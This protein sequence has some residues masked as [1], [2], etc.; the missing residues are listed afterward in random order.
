MWSSKKKYKIA[1]TK[2]H[3]IF[4]PVIIQLPPN[5][6]DCF[7]A[8]RPTEPNRLQHSSFQPR[9]HGIP[10]LPQAGIAPIS[11][12][13]LLRNR[14]DLLLFKMSQSRYHCYWPIW[15]H[16]SEHFNVFGCTKLHNFKKYIK[17]KRERE[18]F[19]KWT[20]QHGT[21]ELFQVH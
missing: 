18:R 6:R 15:L 19:Q 16:D 5:Y 10:L 11:H 3:H 7:S 8:F 13:T 17:N 12:I 2:S 14:T 1:F 20:S 4:I 21:P 9:G